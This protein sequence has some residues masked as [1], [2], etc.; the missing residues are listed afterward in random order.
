M[1][2]LIEV[3]E[4]PRRLCPATMDRVSILTVVHEGDTPFA[5]IDD[6][7]VAHLV[8]TAP[9]LLDLVREYRRVAEYYLRADQAKGDTEGATL[10]MMTISRIDDVLREAGGMAH[11]EDR[12]PA[13][14]PAPVVDFMMDVAAEIE[15]VASLFPGPNPNLAALTEEVGEVARALLEARARSFELGGLDRG[16][17]DDIRTEAVQVAAMAFRIVFEGD[18]TLDVVPE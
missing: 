17:W 3:G 16:D 9:Q 13:M 10:K 2:Q 15:R 8:K 18:P 1:W 11:A 14:A 6:F 4:A 7:A 12:V 5:A